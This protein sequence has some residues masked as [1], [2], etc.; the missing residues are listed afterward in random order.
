M[1]QGSGQGIGSEPSTLAGAVGEM[2]VQSLW[3][4]GNSEDC[5]RYTFCKIVAMFSRASTSTS[6]GVL[7]ERV[8][9]GILGTWGLEFML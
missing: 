4:V 7:G 6:L 5:L 3:V 2:C 8:R 9:G 1:T